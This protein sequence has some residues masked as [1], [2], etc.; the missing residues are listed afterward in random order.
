MFLQ[1]EAPEM[2]GDRA[3]VS[4]MRLVAGSSSCISPEEE[5]ADECL[6][7]ACTYPCS[8]PCLNKLQ[9]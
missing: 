7:H 8:R 6:R 9:K 4:L 1:S 2:Q 5:E 3:A